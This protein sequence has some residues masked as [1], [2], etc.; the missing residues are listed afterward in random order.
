VKLTRTHV[1]MREQY[2]SAVAGLF[3]RGIRRGVF[4]PA[5]L[6]VDANIEEKQ[7]DDVAPG[8]DVDI[9]VEAYPE[10]LSPPHA[11]EVQGRAPDRV[12]DA[13]YRE[14][15]AVSGSVSHN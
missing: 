9:R 12:N 2:R 6:R 8:E 5:T 1:Q 3:A 7:L 14:E 10:A 11:G 15:S 13:Q 4:D